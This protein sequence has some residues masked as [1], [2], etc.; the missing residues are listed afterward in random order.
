MVGQAWAG[1][2]AAGA[3]TAA[4]PTETPADVYARAMRDSQY[5][6]AQARAADLS[7]QVQREREAAAAQQSQTNTYLMVGGGIAAAAL[8]AF[9]V[10]R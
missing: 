5:Q 4:L 1:A 3:T 6:A 7:L 2:S 10:L 8:L 9:L